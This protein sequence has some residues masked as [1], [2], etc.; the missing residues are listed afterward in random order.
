MANKTISNAQLTPG[1]FFY[2]KGQ[3][4]FSRIG[5]HTNQSEL[6]KFNQGRKFKVDNPITE[7][8]IYNA[9]VLY[10]DANNPTVEELYAA[11]SLYT[12]SKKEYTGKCYSPVN[13]TKNLPAVKVQRPDDPTKYDDYDLQGKELAQGLDVVVGMR[14]FKGNG[15]N[16]VSLDHVIVMGEL[17]LR[18]SGDNGAAK[19]ALAKFGITF[20]NEPSPLGEGNVTEVADTSEDDGIDEGAG[21][22]AATSNPFVNNANAAAQATQQA[23][24]APAASSNP[25]NIGAG[26][27]RQ[28]T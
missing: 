22:P 4:G 16:G 11:E 2:V 18:S 13:K 26:V 3:V 6:D 20:T 9:E 28:Y 15:N 7:L 1:R 10:G 17:K 27:K 21:E 14:V 25:F 8:T 5:R 12:S 24:P 23:A 19:S